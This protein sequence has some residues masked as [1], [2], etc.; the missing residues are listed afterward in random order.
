MDKR[1]QSVIGG[2]HEIVQVT[3][4]SEL[5][6]IPVHELNKYFAKDKALYLRCILKRICRSNECY[7]FPSVGEPAY[8]LKG[9]MSH[10]GKGRSWVLFFIERNSVRSW[11]VGTH[12]LFS[13]MD[14]DSAWDR[15]SAYWS[16]W[17]PIQ[18]AA[19]LY[20]ID[21]RTLLQQMVNGQIMAKAGNREQLVLNKDLKALWKTKAE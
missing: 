21:I 6:R 12:Y 9:V 8:T 13:K 1:K 10:T 4:A 19:G 16:E 14:V 11:C 20:G 18:T 7:H 3:Q 2:L 15:E 5:P 17:I